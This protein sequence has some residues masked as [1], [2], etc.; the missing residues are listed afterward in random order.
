M[1]AKESLNYKTTDTED[2]GLK[3]PE[4]GAISLLCLFPPVSLP[5]PSVPISILERSASLPF[6]GTKMSVFKK[7]SKDLTAYRIDELE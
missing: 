2:T 1:Q 6:L 3:T 7:I 5:L 4:E